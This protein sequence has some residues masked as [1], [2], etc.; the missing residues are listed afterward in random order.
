L[1]VFYRLSIVTIA[2]SHSIQPQFAIEFHRP[3]DVVCEWVDELSSLLC[4]TAK[5]P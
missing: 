3:S 5:I 1:V 4:Y 2:L